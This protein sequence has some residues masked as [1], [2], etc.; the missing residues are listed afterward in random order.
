MQYEYHITRRS[1]E[2]T[3]QFKSLEELLLNVSILS[4]FVW[5]PWP[6]M[7]SAPNSLSRR[8]LS[9]KAREDCYAAIK[10]GFIID[11]WVFVL[12]IRHQE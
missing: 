12:S 8:T 1:D 4:V 5:A 10:K 2:C 3:D 11:R 9:E 7:R 6:G